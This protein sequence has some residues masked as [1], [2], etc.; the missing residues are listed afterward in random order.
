MVEVL[1]C[2][3]WCWLLLLLLLLLRPLIP[4]VGPMCC[5]LEEEG[6]QSESELP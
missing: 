5:M 2:T 1:L 4:G 3:C 6:F